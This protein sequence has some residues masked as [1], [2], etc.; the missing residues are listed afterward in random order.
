M[1]KLLSS[2]GGWSYPTLIHIY[3]AE[4]HIRVV[5]DN[6]PVMYNGELYRA[7][8]FTYTPNMEGESSLNIELAETDSIIDILEGNYRFNVD[9]VAVIIEGELQEVRQYRHMYGEGTWT[10]KSLKLKLYKDDR[11]DMSKPAFD[12]NSYNNRGNS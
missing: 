5:N 7:S 12:W 10:G 6:V 1:Y 9:A 4:N 8:N 2:G 3:D 11:L